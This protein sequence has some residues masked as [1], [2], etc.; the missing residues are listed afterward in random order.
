MA[1]QACG[2]LARRWA[3]PAP[4]V[5]AWLEHAP[6][7]VLGL[8]AIVPIVQTGGAFW[9]GATAAAIATRWAGGFTPGLFAA[10]GAVALA[11]LAG[12]GVRASVSSAR[13]G[14]TSN[15]VLYL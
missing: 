14:Q 2:F 4:L 12:P 13:G 11:R 5:P 1:A 6:G 3:R 15:L 9:I 8:A 10:V 7:A